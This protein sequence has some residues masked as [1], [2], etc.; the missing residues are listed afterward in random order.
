MKP[1]RL[2]VVGA[3]SRGTGYGRYAL[4]HP[5]EAKVVAVAEPRQEYRR[6]MVEAHGIPAG[7]VFADWREAADRD[8][9]ADAV[10]IATQDTMHVEPAEAFAAR[11]YAMLLEKPMAPDEAGCRRIVQAAVDNDIL[12]AVCH[13][14]RYTDYTQKLVSMIAD[15][16]VGEVVDIQRVEP[17][18][19][20][21]QAHAFV[22]GN[23]SNEARSS[24]MLLAKSCHD[25]D[26]LRYV[27]G[28]PCRRVSSFGSLFHFRPE[29]RP[30]GAAD[31]C[32]DCPV[33]PDCPYSAQHIYLDR[34]A[35][36]NTGWPV[37]ILA[38][39]VTAE[40]ITEAL[41]TGPYGRC[42]YACDNDV[43]DH[44]VVNMEFEGGRTAGFAMVAFNAHGGR[45]TL[46]HGTRGEIRGDG[47]VLRHLDFLTDTWTE[48]D[49]AATDA[50][51]T[52]G[53]GGGDGRLMQSFL[54]AVATGDR[55]RI[56]S[57]PAETLES[58]LM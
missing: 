22:R 53:H 11:G 56:L 35:A 52:G 9:M 51:I 42:V 41:R 28:V 13:V 3:G 48:I 31:R 19:Y 46:V 23:W 32:L 21:H 54:A 18:G 43:V 4:S 36:G 30:A 34:L 49:T 24:A 44:Q 33:A 14:L 29:N 12:F 50:S 17:V 58:H 57:G 16:A 10:I 45:R 5:D 6:A 20:W 39:E 15:G 25:I 40:S 38:R 27:M 37:S 8:R 26:W 2:L 47:R 55:S 1:V 7:N